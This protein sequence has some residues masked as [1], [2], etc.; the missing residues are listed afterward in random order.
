MTMTIHPGGARAMW[1]ARIP[2]GAVA[3]AWLGQAGFAL[4]HDAWR[5]MIDPYLSDHLARKYKGTESPHVRM[6]PAPIAAE[7]LHG[8]DLVM[9]THRHSDH[10]DPGALP[11]IAAANPACR[12]VVPMAEREAAI[13]AG[14]PEAR[15]ILMNAG[16]DTGRTPVL[17]AIA[18]AH[19][20][21]KVNER[22]EHHFLGYI[23]RLGDLTLYHSG[24]CVVYEGL[25]EEL[26]RQRI[27]LALLPVNGRNAYRTSRGILGNM[28][29][30]EAVELCV[31][32]G[33]PAMLAHHFGMFDFNT[34]DAAE[35]RRR[36]SEMAVR[37]IVPEVGEWYCFGG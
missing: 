14:V 20:Q 3:L 17:R 30:D 6:M 24:D 33:I 15:M 36:A 28:N 16:E 7:D 34:V 5:A 10:M 25:A 19:E 27:D 37:V 18:A 31:D 29:F 32:A 13:K 1:A 9:C 4:R 23:I 2:P 26:R 12:F 11:A 35:L 21:I 22:G 8:V